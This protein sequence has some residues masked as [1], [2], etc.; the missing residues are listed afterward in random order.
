MSIVAVSGETVQF[1][2]SPE[3]VTALTGVFEQP[4]FEANVAGSD[5]MGIWIDLGDESAILLKWQYLATMVVSLPVQE[6]D[7]AKR[8]KIG[9]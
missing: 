9:F 7:E 6:S 4:V 8:N 2:L 5:E 1:R 3:G